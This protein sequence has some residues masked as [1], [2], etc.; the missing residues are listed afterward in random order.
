MDSE[1]KRFLESVRE[2]ISD[3]SEGNNQE[4]SIFFIV[5]LSVAT[6]L[7]SIFV[8]ALSLSRNAQI[9]S[10]EAQIEKQVTVPLNNLKEETKRVTD[11]SVQ[12]DVLNTALSSRVRYPLIVKDLASHTYKESR[13]NSID[14]EEGMVVLSGV[15]DDFIGV[16]KVVSALED[17]GSVKVVDLTSVNIDSQA[18]AIDYSIE[19]EVDETAYTYKARNTINESELEG[20]ARK[21]G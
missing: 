12:L 20:N 5:G 6:V 18:G 8:L 11:I 21:E 17:F 1:E 10:L 3:V 19:F 15:A 7:V 2:D 9:T 4:K 13:W 14:Y 16:S